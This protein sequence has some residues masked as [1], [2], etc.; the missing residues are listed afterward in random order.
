MKVNQT[1]FLNYTH[2]STATS[3]KQKQSNS[4]FSLNASI[5][6]IAPLED[7]WKKLTQKHN[8]RNAS[9]D[10]LCDISMNL[11]NSGKITLKEHAIITFNPNNSSQLI[12]FNYFLSKPSKDGKYDWINEFELRAERN[13]KLGNTLGYTNNKNIVS[14]LTQLLHKQ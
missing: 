4:F 3:T 13:Q 12:D 5:D 9:F 7:I 8:I 10:E 2:L 6:S 11:Y 1:N 14:I